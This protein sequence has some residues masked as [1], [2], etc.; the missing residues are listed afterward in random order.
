MHVYLG[1]LDEW[2]RLIMTM[3]DRSWQFVWQPAMS[4]KQAYGFHRPGCDRVQPGSLTPDTAR[5]GWQDPVPFA[6]PATWLIQPAGLHS[7]DR[8]QEGCLQL[9]VTAGQ[10]LGGRGAA[11]GCTRK[12]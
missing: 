4:H 6:T 10:W 3:R 1:G 11:A 12:E 8:W 7:C 2:Y 5:A 9:H